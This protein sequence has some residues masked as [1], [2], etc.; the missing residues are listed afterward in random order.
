[1]SKL[2]SG[3]RQLSDNELTAAINQAANGFITL[4]IKEGDCVALMLRNDFPFVIASIA[5]GQLGAYVTPINWH[6]TPA[7]F[8]YILDDCGTNFLIIHR[9]LLPQ[10]E[11]AVG[12]NLTVLVVDAPEEIVA[13]YASKDA[14]PPVPASY[15]NWQNWLEQQDN[16]TVEQKLPPASMIYTSGTT[17]H[18]KGVRREPPTATTLAHRLEW[19]IESFGLV[20]DSNYVA[21]MNGPMYHAAPNGYGVHACKSGGTVVFQA[22][23]DPEEMLQLI[24]QH[25]VTHMHIVPTMF[26]RLLKLPDVVRGKYDI[27]SLKF[28]SHGAAPCPTEVKQAM[29]NWWGP[30]VYEY[31]GSTETGIVSVINSEDALQHPGSV[32]RQLKSR[33]IKIFS[34]EGEELKPD[35]IGDIYIDVPEDS[36]FTYHGND[37]K[38]EDISLHGMVTLGDMGYKDT[39]GYLYLCDRRNDMVIS[40]GVNIYPAEI[41][42]QLCQMP[43]I[44]DCVVFGIPHEEFGE[45]LCAHV[46][47]EAAEDIT[48]EDIQNFLKARLASFKVPRQIEFSNNL[49][50]EDSGKIFK[51]KL[52]APYWEESGRQI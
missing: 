14:K 6:Y 37:Q 1:M 44:K 42:M 8:K 16:R 39:D 29:I 31:Y 24:E 4:G 48:A 38:R 21:L 28:V 22:R 47:L 23:F 41:E 27:S 50:R 18:P 40:G 9:D 33:D 17:G 46:E 30:V 45:T 10:I 20:P 32:G 34:E 15:L 7:E 11:G 35:E 49:P 36:N 13:A 43:A 5:A 25:K 51:R 12:F 52:R 2:I 26:S 3:D 19:I